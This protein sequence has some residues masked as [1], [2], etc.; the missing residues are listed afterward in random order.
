MIR[1]TTSDW[2]AA[3][4]LKF[5]DERTRP[6]RDLLAAVPLTGVHNAVDLGCG[7]GNSTELVAARWPDA[8]VSGVDSSPA[9]IEAARARL[10]KL[11]FA[12]ADL[13]HWTPAA[14]PDLIFANAVMQWVPGH[15]AVLRRL[16]AMLAPGGVLAVQM[17]DN[18]DEPSHVAMR[19]TAA[20]GPWAERL[21]AASAAREALPSAESYYDA[22]RPGAAALDIWRTTYHHALADVAAIAEWVKGTGLRP[23]LDPLD[24]QARAAFLA[25]YT[26]RLARHY[27]PQIDGRV[28]LRFPRLFI[29]V[30][31]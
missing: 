9:M 10:P 16:L 31:R 26:E 5:E 22:L 7:P 2:N 20:D 23:F 24:A 19:Q 18:L 30:T 14:P 15:V 29:V 28:I 6:A 8:I 3:Q 4:Y 17:P 1:A 12:M 27:R 25:A 21:A 13:A 11:T